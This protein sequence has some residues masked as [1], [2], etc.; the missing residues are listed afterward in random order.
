MHNSPLNRPGRS[1]VAGAVFAATMF[2]AAALSASTFDAA[3]QDK[4]APKGDEV[5]ATINGNPVTNSDIDMA[6]ADL[7]DQLGQVPEDGRRAA[8]LTALIDIRTLADK[9]DKE[10]FADSQEFKDRMTFLRDRALHNAYF[11]A[12]VVDTISDEDV[13][14]R[15]DKEVAATPAQNEVHALHILVET[16]EAAE[17][18]IKQLD[19]GADFQE[20]AKEKSTGPTGPKGGDLGYFQKGQMVPEFEKAAFGLDV[21]SYT[22]EPVKTQ[23]GW[24]V[25]KVV[26]KRAVQPPAFEQ[27]KDQIKNVLLR[28][29]YFEL[30]QK[31][32]DDANVEITDPDLKKQVEDADTAPKPAQ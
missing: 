3:A 31:L 21:G 6:L 4:T 17:D 18:I 15:Y 13:R 7:Q 9:A 20:L 16:K 32:R 26:D 19:D 8:A 5:V 22:K 30:V 14:A 24:H 28:E 27:V 12:Q 2:V 23:F 25:I 10:G 11:R 29:R 1:T